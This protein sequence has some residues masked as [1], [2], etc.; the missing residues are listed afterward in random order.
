MSRLITS[1]FEENNLIETVW[2]TLS[3]TGSITTNS[4]HSG[5]YRFETGTATGNQCI[6]FSFNAIRNSGSL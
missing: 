2:T 3:G 6:R 1:G 5:T 4:P